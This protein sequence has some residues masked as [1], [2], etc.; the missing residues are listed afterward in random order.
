M[1]SWPTSPT[2]S[3]RRSPASRDTSRRS[4]TARS[5]TA[6]TRGSS[7][8]SPGRTRSGWTGSSTTCSSCP[9]SRAVA[10]PWRRCG[11]SWATSSA[12]V[13]AMFE[14]Q[15]VQQGLVFE[16][17]VPAG[18]A[19]RADRDRL[20]QILV[21]LVDNAV[22][23]TPEG[24]SIRIEA[25]PGAGRTRRDPRVR[26]GHRD[27]VDGPPADHRALLPRGQ[28]AVARD[29]GDGSRTGDRQ[30][31]GPG[32]WRRA[33]HR[34]RPR[35]RHH[36]ELHGARG[37][38]TRRAPER[39]RLGDRG[40][41]HRHPR[42]LAPD[43][44]GGASPDPRGDGR[45]RRG[46]AARRPPR[47]PAWPAAS[48]GRGCRRARPGGRGG[49]PGG[50]RPAAGSPARLPRAADR[51]TDDPRGGSSSPPRGVTC[52]RGSG[53]GAGRSSSTRSGLATAGGSAI[54]R[55][56]GG[57]PSGPRARWE[58]ARCS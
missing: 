25:A 51:S 43:G 38:G 13:A 33:S 21:N 34:E 2:S 16:R 48:R 53:R 35:A 39:R 14:R 17:A 58:R 9:T 41:L 22:K 8:R 18:L 12:G 24:G 40:R 6:R 1:S 4:S 20:V 10:S 57:S 15:A 42:G 50:R 29:R 31:P 52:R 5:T 44:G 55:T 36:R 37:R 28:D 26:H 7:S 3:G 46:A 45:D 19:V 11:S 49:P 54:S 47:S 30:A 32:P 56:C 23:F 27:P